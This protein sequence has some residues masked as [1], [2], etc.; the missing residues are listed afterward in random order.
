[1]KRKGV[2]PCDYMDPPS[3]FDDDKLPPKQAFY[4]KLNDEHITDDDYV[5][6]QLVWEKFNKKILESTRTCI[7]RQMSFFWQMFLRTFAGSV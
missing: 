7:S 3:K 6:A 4:S 1:M 2:Y 5:H